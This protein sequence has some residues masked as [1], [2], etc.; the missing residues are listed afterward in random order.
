[1]NDSNAALALPMGV[2]TVQTSVEATTEIRMVK[3]KPGQGKLNRLIAKAQVLI[4]QHGHAGK[5]FKR[6]YDNGTAV[7]TCTHCQALVVIDIHGTAG[8]MGGFALTTACSA[9]G[10]ASNEGGQNA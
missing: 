1:M 6:D 4:A 9:P 8:K 5:L 7:Y 2:E 10:V 3:C